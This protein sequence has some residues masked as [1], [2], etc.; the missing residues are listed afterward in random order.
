MVPFV[1]DEYQKIGG[2]P[3]N[4]TIQILTKINE[5]SQSSSHTIS[6]VFQANSEP[7][8]TAGLAKAA[9]LASY[10]VSWRLSRGISVRSRCRKYVN[11]A[12]RKKLSQ[13]GG[14]KE[15]KRVSRRSRRDIRSFP[16]FFSRSSS[17]AIP[18]EARESLPVLSSHPLTVFTLSP[19]RFFSYSA[20]S[21]SHCSQR[22]WKSTAP[23]PISIPRETDSSTSFLVG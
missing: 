20:R 12:S 6:I 7:S 14:K 19:T 15:R 10:Q 3:F 21:P 5:F 13:R 2:I 22:R 9:R 1:S 8:P 18:F 23:R 4:S 17:T 16:W 11:L